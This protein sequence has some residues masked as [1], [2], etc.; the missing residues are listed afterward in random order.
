M[1]KFYY[2]KQIN[3][4]SCGLIAVKY[5]LWSVFFILQGRSIELALSS[6][7]G[8][9]KPLMSILGLYM[10]IKLM[11][12]FC[13]VGY[14]L[15]QGLLKNKE[16]D[17]QWGSLYPSRLYSD[18]VRKK[19]EFKLL[20]FEY[21]P[22]IF[23]SKHVLFANRFTIVFIV[24]LTTFYFVYTQFYVGILML[25]CLFFLNYFSKNIFS[26]KIDEQQK[27]T[28]MLKQHVMNW[29][30]QYFSGYHEI[31][32]NWEP[33]V[34]ASW[35]KHVYKTL[36]QGK[37]KLSLYYAA[38]DLVC[39]C[40]V[41]LPFILNTVLI[42]LAVYWRYLS[43]AQ[44][45]VWI[46]MSQFIM[47]A[48][49]ALAKNKI[50]VRKVDI[51]EG[52]ADDIICIFSIAESSLGSHPSHD[53]QGVINELASLDIHFQDGTL[54]KLSLS[55]GL[56]QIKGG[57]GSGKTTLLDQIKGFNRSESMIY[58]E[59]IKYFIFNANKKNIRMIERNAVVFDGLPSFTRQIM[60]PLSGAEEPWIERIEQNMAMFVTTPVLKAWTQ[61][62][63]DLQAKYDGIEGYQLS[64]G[65]RI[66]LSFAR[67]WFYWDAAVQL[68][69]IDECD[70]FLDVTKRALFMETIRLVSIKLPVFMVSH[71]ERSE[72]SPKLSPNLADW[73]SLT[74]F[75][76]T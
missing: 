32:K 23:N 52:L 1:I 71:S 66:I 55:P 64:S 57:N 51:L 65:E 4:L 14:E 38:R 59:H 46:G 74:A 70:G 56:H 3:R 54:N 73:R 31:S 26:K 28:Q 49:N 63:G 69:L 34:Y 25:L 41:E 36:Y 15:I 30:D 53:R 35:H 76:M 33:S 75:G 13:D 10:L 17:A 27:K 43:I 9:L 7:T 47:T 12:M 39:Q 8:Q 45:F 16:T 37:H 68:V 11:V 40:L 5:T 60:G 29:S 42:I 18:N 22:E 20:M 58:S 19:N 61:I 48:S 72:G 24:F 67:A 62:L 50:M 21:I 6:E 2:L 44:L